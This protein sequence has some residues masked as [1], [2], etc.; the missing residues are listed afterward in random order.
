[1]AARFTFDCRGAGTA[2]SHFWEHTVGSD[3]ARMALRADWRAQLERA[4][5]ELG[6]RH[7]RFHGVLD[8][9]MGTLLRENDR[10]LYS[11]FNADNIVDF[12]L[13]IGMRPFIE[14]SFMPSALSSGGTTV[15]RYRGNVTPPK[16]LGQWCTLIERLVRHWVE[17]YGVREVRNWFFEI[18]NE[19][20]LA[21]F[22]TGSQQDYFDFYRRTAVAI[23]GI[24]A[25]LR[26]GG[27]ASAANAWIHDFVEYCRGANAPL[28]FISTHHYPTDAFGAPGDDTV[29]QLSKSR[30][31][32][33]REE[34][35]TV[36]RQAGPLPVYYTEWSSSS[37]PR[38]PLHD[39][40]FAAAFAVKT[41]LEAA[42]LVQGYSWWTFSDIFEENYFPAKPFE[43]GFGLLNVDGIAKPVYRAFELMHGL[44]EEQL[45]RNG[46]H[47]T[48]DA[49]AVRGD[50]GIRVIVTN[51]ALPRHPV[52]N[53]TV[54]VVLV[55]YRGPAR[56]W[57]R[58]VD[59]RHANAPAAWQ[60]MHRPPFPSAAQVRR[61]AR[62]SEIVAEPLR[63]RATR[64]ELAIGVTV[65]PQGIAA[66]D[67]KPSR[68]DG[69]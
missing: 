5:R 15:F 34:A 51:F 20:N 69:H 25:R 59:A 45:A 6:F 68:A 16:D 56:A 4:H 66:I 41:V 61:L 65:P 36:R 17:R 35:Q 11:F 19:P 60:R 18:W 50:K 30:R 33:L 52:K 13:S 42:G 10:L 7:V 43:G 63:A 37:N 12:L 3:H 55:H 64:G 49:W 57:L 67:V 22:W 44:G 26:V 38:D 53:E 40:P 47:P 1:M 8:D 62:A 46:A 29:T 39:E 58:R 2:L 28:D 14:L 48:V 32:V 23:K 24:D 27:P 9:D 31:S 21:A 54:E